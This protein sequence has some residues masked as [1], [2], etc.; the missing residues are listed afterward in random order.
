MRMGGRRR[1]GWRYKLLP[2][3]AIGFPA[4][5]FFDEGFAF[6][7]D[8]VDVFDEVFAALG[9]A[10]HGDDGVALG[11]VVGD[12][13]GFAVGLEAIGH[14]LDEV[15]GGFSFSRKYD[16]EWIGRNG[17]RSF[18]GRASAIEEERD[19]RADAVGVLGE[20]ADERLAGAGGMARGVRH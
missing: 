3:V 15:V 17:F 13:E 10:A 1:F 2:L 12:G 9:H 4:V 16:L 20:H 5:V 19:R 7:E 18:L 6:A 11:V 8:T 14:T